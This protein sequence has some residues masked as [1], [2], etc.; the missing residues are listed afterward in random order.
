MEN[1]LSNNL[2][3]KY[4]QTLLH[5][6]SAR[7]YVFDITTLNECF[8]N[9]DV[10]NSISTLRPL[11][12]KY[13]SELNQIGK[14]KTGITVKKDTRLYEKK[15]DDDLMFDLQ[16]MIRCII[17]IGAVHCGLVNNIYLALEQLHDEGYDI[18]DINS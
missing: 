18:N 11:V 7:R 2:L 14:Y 13:R 3:T 12:Y 1:E 8:L 4:Y 17:L 16:Y 6:K 9:F 15:T 5:L 10:E